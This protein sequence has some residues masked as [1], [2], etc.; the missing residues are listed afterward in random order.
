MRILALFSLVIFCFAC[1]TKEQETVTISLDEV[2]EGSSS[3]NEL[4]T[5]VVEKIQVELDEHFVELATILEIP[6][7]KVVEQDTVLFVDRFESLSRFKYI[8]NDDKKPLFIAK[9]N[10][11]N[12]T[13]AK[14]AFINWT[15]CYGKN[16]S[17]LD[18]KADKSISAEN[19]GM[20]LAGSQLLYWNNLSQKD[21]EKAIN[22]W[23]ELEKIETIEYAFYQQG[24]KGITWY[25]LTEDTQKEAK[26]LSARTALNL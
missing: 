1:Q 19:M 23:I 4:D 21:F 15:Q 5:L 8:I 26:I 13:S 10:Y 9:W 2:I 7:D 17:S 24:K 3:Q 6:L 12:A 18:F 25:E 14:N 11:K 22:E 16:C 20:V